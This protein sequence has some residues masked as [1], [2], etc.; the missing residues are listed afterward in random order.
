MAAMALAV[1]TTKSAAAEWQIK[2]A[3]GV[4]FGGKTT[5]VDWEDAVG[6]PNPALSVNGT[7]LGEVFGLEA[8]VGFMP[9]LFDRDGERSPLDRISG[10]VMCDETCVTS[11]MVTTYTANVV[12]AVPRRLTEYTLRPYIVGGGGLMRVSVTEG[13]GFGLYDGVSPVNIAALDVGGGVTGFLTDRLGLNW[14]LRWFR[15]LR[16]RQQGVS[17]G[18]E[19]LS[20][21]RASMAVAVRY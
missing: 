13:P 6:I 1:L 7:L 19:K 11:S 5:F 2:P 18:R 8:D 9:G 16:G 21:W 17:L 14:D 12:I 4:T 15:S 3:V 10:N 20:F